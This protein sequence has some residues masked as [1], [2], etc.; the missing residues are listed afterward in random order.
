MDWAKSSSNFATGNDPSHYSPSQTEVY[1]PLDPAV[2]ICPG[3][4]RLGGH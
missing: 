1:L 4:L 3:T 2:A